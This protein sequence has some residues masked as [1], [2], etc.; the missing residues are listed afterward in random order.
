MQETLT[1]YI[2][3]AVTRLATSKRQSLQHSRGKAEARPRFDMKICKH[4]AVR[5]RA[6]TLKSQAHVELIL[7]TPD[8]QVAWALSD[9]MVLVEL[10]ERPRLNRCGR[11]AD[12]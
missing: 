10:K 9:C 11:R 5:V 4:K 6:Q 3:T 1:Q 12:F 2:N 7:L 8:G